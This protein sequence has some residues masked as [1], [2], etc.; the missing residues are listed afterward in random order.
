[1]RLCR[2]SSDLGGTSET[3]GTSSIFHPAASY[4]LVQDDSGWYGSRT[5]ADDLWALP[6]WRSTNP[7]APCLP[8]SGRPPHTKARARRPGIDD[9]KAQPS[10]GRYWRTNLGTPTADLG[11][12]VLHPALQMRY[13]IHSARHIEPL[14]F[15]LN[16]L[17][18]EDA[19]QD[20]RHVAPPRSL[21]PPTLYLAGRAISPLSDPP[22]ATL[23]RSPVPRLPAPSNPD[24]FDRR[25]TNGPCRSRQGPQA[26]GPSVEPRSPRATWTGPPPACPRADR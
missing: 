8:S 16:L 20:L 24:G 21:R 10:T 25:R 5:G 7:I 15:R 9:P 12:T 18:A 11:T 6:N 2:Q 19:H 3:T 23:R 22:V 26:L 1:L 17:E 14:L 4:P 13:F